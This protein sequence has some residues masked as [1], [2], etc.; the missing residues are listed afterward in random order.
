[1]NM[2]KHVISS[3]RRLKVGL[4]ARFR[5]SVS[6]VIIIPYN[7]FT[8]TFAVVLGFCAFSEVEEGHFN[9]GGGAPLCLLYT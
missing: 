8:G 6:S 7:Y 3:W 5:F 2:P 4:Q 9:R 1:M